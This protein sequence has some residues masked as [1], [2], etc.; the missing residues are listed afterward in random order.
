VTLCVAC[1]FIPDYRTCRF[2]ILRLIFRYR[3]SIIS[4]AMTHM[5]HAYTCVFFFS[6]A[7]IFT[8]CVIRVSKYS[9][10]VGNILKTINHYP[11]IFPI[12]FTYCLNFIF[13]VSIF[14]IPDYA[15]SYLRCQVGSHLTGLTYRL[16]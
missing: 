15:R 8:P 3:L 2:T 16:R 7:S 5:T 6:L 11:H 9:I 12:L 13:H 14:V 4:Q 1:F 10:F